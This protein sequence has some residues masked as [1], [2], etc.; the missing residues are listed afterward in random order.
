MV[1]WKLVSLKEVCQLLI[2]LCLAVELWVSSG[3]GLS[4]VMMDSQE[5]QP[6][7]MREVLLGPPQL[8]GIAEVFI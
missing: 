6:A 8:R 4:L 3:I 7:L 1:L 2:S 5:Q